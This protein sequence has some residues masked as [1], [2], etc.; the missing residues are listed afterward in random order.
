MDPPGQEAMVIDSL[1]LKQYHEICYCYL[2]NW[3]NIS[4][5]TDVTVN[6]G[7]VIVISSND[8]LELPVEIASLL[9]VN[10]HY[11]DWRGAKWEVMAARLD[12]V[13]HSVP[14]GR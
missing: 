14:S 4:I 12:P 13:I 2:S 8:P 3:G 10:I 7:S 5:S 1:T 6:L 9:D 11:S